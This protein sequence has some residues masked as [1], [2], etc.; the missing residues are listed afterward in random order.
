MRTSENN[1]LLVLYQDEELLVI[2]KPS[3]LL[4][5]QDGYHSD[6]PH[7]RTVLEPIY[8]KLWLVHRLDKDSSGLIILARNAT[9]HRE[10]NKAFRESQIEKIYHG[11][12]APVPQWREMDIQLPLLPNADREHRTRVNTEKGKKAHSYC[13]I[14][15]WFD[16]GVLMKI[17]IH[18]GITHQI[19][20]HLRAYNLALL[21]DYLYA[22]GLNPQ[23]FEVSRTML[24]AREIAFTHPSKKTWLRF[25]APY[26]DDFRTAY[27]RLK[28]TTTLDAMI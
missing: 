19:R 21:G 15:K 1:N 18:T 26:P 5:I 17:Q 25:T 9:T 20:A 7:L 23:P 13:S 12:V 11:L 16:L 14:I 6:Y 28:F 27:E 2:N 22:A 3:G 24:H 8:G 10:L 4:S